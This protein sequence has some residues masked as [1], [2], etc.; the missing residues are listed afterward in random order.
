MTRHSLA[1]IAVLTAAGLAAAQ[2]PQ[3]RPAQKVDF[4]R[5]RAAMHELREARKRLTDAKDTWPP[6]YKERALE[7]TQAA[8][9]SIRVMLAVKDVDT[10][11]GVDRNDDYYKKYSDHPRLRAA[12]DDLRDARDELKGEKE[13]VGP[14][15]QDAL[16]YIDMAVGD[17]VRLI[18]HTPKK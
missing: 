17:I 18:R 6:G 15:R 14:T 3:P 12:V 7:S 8:M 16:D 5:L 2:S 4:P 10:F 1:L 9:D 13:K 11:V